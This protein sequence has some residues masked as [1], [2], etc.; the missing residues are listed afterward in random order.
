MADRRS[1][2]R[3]GGASAICVAAAAACLQ[4]TRSSEGERLRPY[5]D[6]ANIVTWCYGE[7]QG[8]PQ[9][10]YT[11]DQCAALLDQRLA[12]DYAPKIV[13]C[14]PELAD[15]RRVKVFAAL[16]DAAYNA[17]P[18]AVCSSPMKAY[19]RAGQFS[20]A[21]AAFYDWFT[22]ARYRG[23]PQPA[24]AMIRSGWQWDGRA[25]RKTLPGLVTRRSKEA[26]LCMDGAV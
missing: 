9:A 10:R 18:G 6:P 21:C 14:M 20:A 17:G 22:T 8:R 11:S 23:K 15:Q 16:L 2:Q 12:R 7:T 3:V 1:V 26:R 19:V 5:R 4:L 13:G 24:A 25:W